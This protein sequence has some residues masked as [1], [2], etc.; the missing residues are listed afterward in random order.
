M[1]F[2]S[3]LFWST[4]AI[5][6]YTQMVYPLLMYLFAILPKRS[7]RVASTDATALPSVTL[8][9]PAYN[10]ELVIAEKLENALA[11]DYPAESL[12]IIV[13]SDGSDDGTVDIAGRF[14]SRGVK[15]LPFEGRRGKASVINDAISAASGS[16]VC[17]CD[18]NVMFEAGAL[19]KLVER[20]ADSEVGAVSGEVRLA[21]DESNFGQGESAYYGI[22][23]LVQQGESEFGS[24]IGVDG[25]MYALR[26]EL[27]EP[28]PPDTVLDD[29]VIAMQV[30]R[31]GKRV[32]YE[33]EA[34]ATENGTELA[35]QE[36]RRRVRVSAGAAQALK[37]GD[38]PPLVRPIEFWQFVSHKLLRW[39]GPAMLIVLLASNV[40][41]WNQGVVYRVTGLGQVLLY[42]L[43]ALATFSLRFRNTR[44]GG[45]VF[46]F[47]LSHV[48]MI[49]GLIK[50]FLSRQQGTWTRTERRAA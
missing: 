39:L 15:L 19:K 40:L 48:A 7:H 33:P 28:L 18:A 17:L 20:F 25:G 26:R 24:L 3:I 32:V 16:V 27:F 6:I 9:I 4:V 41:L 12:E 43:A 45:V 37:R 31:R 50:G 34:V 30:I 46:Y 38:W 8:I 47:V 21:S 11:L 44:V 5:C 10:E 42:A 1:T 49:P 22:E 23:R 35:R 13:A 36:F 2:V 14:E 29:F